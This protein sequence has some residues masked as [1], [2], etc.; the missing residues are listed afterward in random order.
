M[1]QFKHSPL[2][3]L[4]A[5]FIITSCEKRPETLDEY[6][7]QVETVSAE[8]LPNGNMLV[9]G[10][11]LEDGHGELFF[12]GFSMDTV[13]NS[14]ISTNQILVYEI[15]GDE[16]FAEYDAPLVQFYSANDIYITAFAGNEHTYAKG[17]SLLANGE[18][19]GDTSLVVPC[20][21]QP[22]GADMS[23]IQGWRSFTSVSEPQLNVWGTYEVTGNLPFSSAVVVSYSNLISGLYLTQSLQSQYDANRLTIQLRMGSQ[24]Y[25]LPS[26]SEV[27]VLQLDENSFELTVCDTPYNFGNS[28]PDFSMRMVIEV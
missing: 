6:L 19:V 15:Y 14:L 7:P 17:N 21:L 13:P 9:T 22:N 1:M 24:T 11:L 28:T 26:N 23:M 20:E 27:Y 4:L 5:L 3:F 2:Y 25:S 18:F 8:M 10:R 12:V 16:F